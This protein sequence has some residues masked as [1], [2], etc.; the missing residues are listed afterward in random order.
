MPVFT[1]LLFSLLVFSPKRWTLR[2]IRCVIEN[3]AYTGPGFNRTRIAPTPSGYLHLG[4]V[5]SFVLTAALARASGARILLRI[6]DLDHERVRPTYIEDIFDTLDFLELPW[7]EGPRN[8]SEFEKEYAQRHRLP[9]YR[10]ALEEL[11]QGD[12]VFACTCSRTQLVQLNGELVHDGNCRHRHLPLDTPAACWRLRT[13][14][15]QRVTVQ[16]RSGERLHPI[17][18]LSMHDFMVRK[19]DGWPSYQLA[20][21]IDDL[22]Y[23][24]GLI[25][26]GADLWPS[27]IAQHYLAQTLGRSAF[28]EIRF[29][30]HPLMMDTEG[31]KLS[32][33]AGATSVYGLRKEGKKKE[34]IYGLIAKALGKKEPASNWQ[35]L[36]SLLSFSETS[37]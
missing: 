20:S 28:S 36:A 23:G 21:V 33:S 22:Y 17:L 14:C 15:A 18:P 3:L 7:N 35:E 31:Q 4:N 5:L 37:V 32:K 10:K 25:V 13:D 26:R 34:E 30:H 24:I 2:T 16:L 19:K 1:G 6:D 8:V 27:T 9:L 11:A 29:Y 12:R